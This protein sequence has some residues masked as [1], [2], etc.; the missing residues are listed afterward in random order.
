[1]RDIDR[2]DRLTSLRIESHFHCPLHHISDR[3]V[4]E[5]SIDE[6]PHVSPF[7]ILDIEEK[8]GV[9]EWGH[10]HE[11]FVFIFPENTMCVY[12][13]K[14]LPI[15][16]P[17]L[18][19]SPTLRKNSKIPS[20]KIISPSPSPVSLVSSHSSD[21]SQKNSDSQ[22]LDDKIASSAVHEI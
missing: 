1:M 4:R 22:K 9:S 21:G 8:L 7:A 10:Y 20:I 18:R 2:I 12:F 17:C 11:I 16:L 13:Q 5:P 19:S 3:V 15:L 6:D 14:N